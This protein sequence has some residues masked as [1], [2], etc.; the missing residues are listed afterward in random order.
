MSSGPKVEQ[1]RVSAPDHSPR[2]PFLQRIEALFDRFF[3]LTPPLDPKE[4]DGILWEDRIHYSATPLVMIEGEQG[5]P[6][7]SSFT[8]EMIEEA[9][10]FFNCLIWLMRYQRRPFR[11]L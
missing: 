10:A 5:V 9:L 8:P 3:R 6:A 1:N 2:K 11:I 7:E 4:V